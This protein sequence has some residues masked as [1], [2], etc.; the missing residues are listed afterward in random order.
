MNYFL[1]LFS[2]ISFFAFSLVHAEGNMFREGYFQRD[3]PFADGYIQEHN[4]FAKGYIQRTH[5]FAD[6]TKIRGT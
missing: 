6:Q 5:P 4:P 1:K 3:N 2:I